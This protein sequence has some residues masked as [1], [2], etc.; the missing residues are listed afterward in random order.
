MKPFKPFQK[1]TF[2]TGEIALCK[3][4]KMKGNSKEW[5]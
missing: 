3:T 1:L 5:F 4:E 2:V